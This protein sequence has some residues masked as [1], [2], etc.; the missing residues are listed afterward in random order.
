M[1]SYGFNGY[2]VLDKSLNVVKK[3]NE[4]SRIGENSLKSIISLCSSDS[5]YITKNLDI[6]V[7]DNIYSV[8]VDI[9]YNDN[10][11]FISIRKNVELELEQIK[12]TINKLELCFVDYDAV[13]KKI[14]RVTYNGK[15]LAANVTL[16]DILNTNYF[17]VTDDFLGEYEKGFKDF[18]E[19]KLNR[20]VY[21]QSTFPDGELHWF[22]CEPIFMNDKSKIYHACIR[23]EDKFANDRENLI[24]N[25]YK[26]YLTK[27]YNKQGIEI[28]AKELLEGSNDPCFLGILDVDF[29]KNINDRYG[30]VFGDE[31]LKKVASSIE[32]KLGDRGLIGRIGGDEF[33]F[34]VKTDGTEERDVKPFLRDI[35]LEL[36]NCT[37]QGIEG[38]HISITI[39]AVASPTY[40]R[41]YEELYKL[42]D[43]A[44]YRGKSKGRDC[45]I[46]YDVLK[47]GSIDTSLKS[48]IKAIEPGEGIKTK[49]SNTQMINQCIDKL[50]N[51]LD[52]KKTIL[53][54]LRDICVHFLID[55]ATLADEHGHIVAQYHSPDTVGLDKFYEFAYDD[56]YKDRFMMDNMMFCN[57]TTFNQADSV[58]AGY[59]K[60]YGVY[61]F[62]QFKIIQN[63]EFK[64]YISFEDLTTKRVWQ[65]DELNYCN[66]LSKI[67]SAFYN[68]MELERKL[69]KT[70]YIDKVTGYRNL[71]SFKEKAMT[72]DFTKR[73]MILI[74]FDIKN[75]TYV[76]ENIGL[77]VGDRVLKHIADLMHDCVLD[78]ELFCHVSDDKFAILLNYDGDTVSRYRNL[79][80]KIEEECTDI[81][82]TNIVIASG[83][84]VMEGGEDLNFAI[85][86]A[87]Q[88]RKVAKSKSDVKLMFYDSSFKA[89]EIFN[90]TLEDNM[91]HALDNNEFKVYLQP[92]YYIKTK[93]VC[94]MEALVR[95][96][97]KGEVLSPDKFIPLFESNGFVCEL[98]FYV[99]EVVCWYLKHFADAGYDVPII[100]V[101]VSR[102]HL[103]DGNFIERLNRLVDKYNVSRSLIGLELTESMFVKNEKLMISFVNNLSKAGYR[104]YMD[105]FGVAYSTLNLLS[106]MHVDVIKLDKA[107]IDNNMFNPNERIIISNIIRMAKELGIKV[108][109]EGIETDVQLKELTKLK[110]DYAQGYWFSKPKPI[111]DLF[112]HSLTKKPENN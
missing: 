6:N 60:Y 31:V 83:A 47:H 18:T 58:L 12:D 96:E 11:Y 91:Q 4:I 9:F 89:D 46:I 80:M 38:I 1:A 55:R 44:L 34:I 17:K 41:D 85:D 72:I 37:I 54:V 8:V 10:T 5:E 62:V 107:F 30:H 52:I 33:L 105:D 20:I 94:S 43:K 73:S 70:L 67:I 2:L 79:R 3:S 75:F 110:C 29:F 77:K 26:D 19:G 112:P 76:N 57:Q 27:I 93:K 109:S 32:R 35:K 22:V 106:R 49:I 50:V 53:E 65:M 82:K 61:A 69:T 103:D 64:G 90:K 66:I 78:D 63:G 88:A 74:A 7:D 86:K 102:R 23:K 111:D 99:Y 36:Q 108:L 51:S 24:E 104:I 98:D 14:V 92:C 81:C 48:D 59:N 95:W 21:F 25:G 100:S 39:G 40:G 15:V 97:F 16:D 101:N 71:T 84:Y 13:N 28:N 56:A 45:H 42:A 68:K 87:N